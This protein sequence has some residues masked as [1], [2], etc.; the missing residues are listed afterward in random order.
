MYLKDKYDRE[1]LA[2]LILTFILG[3]LTAYP[4]VQI[5]TFLRNNTFLTDK[6]SLLELFLYILVVIALVEEC[7]KYAVWRLFIY[8][9]EV[10]SEPFDGIVYS[11]AAGMGFAAVENIIYVWDGGWQTGLVRMF[12]A[13]PVHGA[14]A[15][16]VGYY[17]G[18]AKFD[19]NKKHATWLHIKGLGLAILFHTF[20]DFFI[21]WDWEISAL[22]SFVIL[23]FG[24]RYALLALRIRQRQVD[25]V[26]I[27]KRSH[28]VLIEQ[29]EPSEEG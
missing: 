7:L 8:P 18:W 13:V 12:T 26:L 14:C 25:E 29:E 19:L 28:F 1:P 6:G 5:G 3:A 9:Q 22:F 21:F 24:L 20:Y 10:F 17:A 23:G 11:I 4:V 2:Y 16:Y 27:S 15:A